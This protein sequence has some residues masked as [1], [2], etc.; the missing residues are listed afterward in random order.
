MIEK[1]VSEKASGF[2]AASAG[3]DRFHFFQK[4]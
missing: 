1:K 4:I 2:G 3:D